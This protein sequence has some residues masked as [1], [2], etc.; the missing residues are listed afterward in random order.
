MIKYK[1]CP[2]CAGRLKNKFVHGRK[3]LV[4]SKCR[5]VFYQNSK[6]TVAGLI[7]RGSK[8]LLV[9]RSIKPKLGYWDVPGGFLEEG[10]EPIR[11]LKRELREELKLTLKNIKFLGIYIDDYLQA[12]LKEKVLSLYYLAQIK[13]GKIRPG[14]DVAEAKWFSR[15][16]IPR[17]MAFKGN[18]EA[19]RGWKKLLENK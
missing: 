6:P 7:I 10:E 11:G 1:F 8:I 14:D 5:F 16:K 12:G 3:R 17:Q 18:L 13:S 19:I 9:K 4:C 15:H 2:V